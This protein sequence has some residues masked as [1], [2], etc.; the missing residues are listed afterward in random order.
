MIDF[1][2]TLGAIGDKIK[3]ISCCCGHNKY[4]MTVV[5][6]N[7]KGTCWEL[8]SG[9]MIYRKRSFY[10]RDEQGYYYIPETII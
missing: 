9:K 4:P 2:Y 10:K 7:R 3:P 1:I 8:I 6:R 5:V